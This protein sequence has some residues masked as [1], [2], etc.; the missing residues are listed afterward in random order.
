MNILVL[1]RT[2]TYFI[3]KVISIKYIEDKTAFH[4]ITQKFRKLG[5][6]ITSK[7]NSIL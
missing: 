3:E 4:L 5:Q 7:K 6:Y 2:T 1:K